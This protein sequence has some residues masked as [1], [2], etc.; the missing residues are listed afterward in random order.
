MFNKK[1]LGEII[2][3]WIS[4]GPNLPISQDQVQ[5]ALGDEGLQ[6][7]ATSAGISSDT[8]RIQLAELLPRVADQMTP[9]GNIPKGTLMHKAIGFVK[10]KFM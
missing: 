9:D 1:G 5:Q 10:A 3:S 4:T 8:A 2:S 6:Q 7:L